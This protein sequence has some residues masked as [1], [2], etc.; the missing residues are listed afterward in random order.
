MVARVLPVFSHVVSRQTDMDGWTDGRIDIQAAIKKISF[1]ICLSY[2]DIF[3][4]P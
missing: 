3:H 4:S 2:G 1:V